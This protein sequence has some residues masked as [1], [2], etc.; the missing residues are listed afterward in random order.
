M[1]D[2]YPAQDV[3]VEDFRSSIGFTPSTWPVGT[4]VMLC[5]VPWDSSYCDVVY[6]NTSAARDAYFNGLGAAETVTLRNYTYCKPNEPIRVNIPYSQAYTYNYLVVRNPAMPV[7]GEVTPPTLYYFINQISMVAPNTTN[8]YIQLD[9]WMTYQLG[10]SFGRSFVERGHVA[11]HA[12]KLSNLSGGAPQKKRRYLMAPEGLDVGSSY[13]ETSEEQHQLAG[14]GWMIIVMSAVELT[15]GTSQTW[16]DVYGDIDNPRLRVATPGTTDGFVSGC[17]VYALSAGNFQLFASS[18]TGYPWIANQ[19]LTISAM[20]SD[21]FY[22]DGPADTYLPGNIP[23]L[24]VRALNT[25]FDNRR[26]GIFSLDSTLDEQWPVGW[27]SHEKAHVWPFSYLM[28]DNQMSPPVLL[29][30]EL[31]N[32]NANAVHQDAFSTFAT[33]MPGFQRIFVY[34]RNYGVDNTADRINP[35]SSSR[36]FNGDAISQAVP[37]GDKLATALVWQEFPQFAIYNDGYLM[38]LAQNAHTFAYS[39]DNAGWQLDK[40]LANAQTS[41]DNAVRSLGAA[42]ANQQLAYETQRDIS[43]YSMGNLVGNQLRDTYN[44]LSENAQGAFN[45]V[46]GGADVSAIINTTVNAATGATANEVGNL[47]F[48]TTQAAQQGNLDANYALQQW[49]AR[50]DY[51]QSIAAI[52]ANVQD[53]QLTPPNQAGTYAGGMSA[54]LGARGMFCWWVKAY[55]VTEDYQDRIRKFWDRFGY[56]VGEYI[57]VG[58]KF[59]LMT[60]FTYWKMQDTTLTSDAPMDEGARQIIRGIFEKGVTVWR[61]PDDIGASYTTLV[62]AVSSTYASGPLY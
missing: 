51:S 62:N 18:L 5:N 55:T 42:Q 29:K 34:P 28:L 9:V 11:R 47:Q 14:T 58:R 3:G 33:L 53:A 31:F 15:R 48:Q 43:R 39:R 56:A 30:P 50:G 59:C 40:S 24:Y 36:S 19:I 1:T 2:A 41:Y 49:A 16:T 52:E 44:K 46:F 25:D 32:G 35:A 7:A 12:Y 61:D 57:D 10:V 17:C 23:A 4:E 20:P 6:F 45:T 26:G 22:I 37:W 38:Y 54:V 60:K 8:L 27:S 21:L 13:I